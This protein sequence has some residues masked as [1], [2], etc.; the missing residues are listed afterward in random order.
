[1]REEESVFMIL[2]FHLEN[3]EIPVAQCPLHRWKETNHN[4]P[5]DLD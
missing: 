2:V 3:L 5:S 1:M 4:V